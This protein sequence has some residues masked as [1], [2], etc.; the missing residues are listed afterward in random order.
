MTTDSK[1][2]ETVSHEKAL[3]ALA[4]FHIGQA[5]WRM[6]QQGIQYNATYDIPGKLRFSY[7]IVCSKKAGDRLT[8]KISSLAP[9]IHCSYI[10]P[11]LEYDLEVKNQKIK[12]II[13]RCNFDVTSKL[14]S[15]LTKDQKEKAKSP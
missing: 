5:S 3:A 6:A 7:D 14:F 9:G 8:V 10:L 13:E 1:P 15:L 11:L 12:E 4:L 2:V